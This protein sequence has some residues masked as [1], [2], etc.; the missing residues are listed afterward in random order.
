MSEIKQEILITNQP[1]PVSVRGTKKILSQM[2]KFICKIYLGNGKKGTGTGF[3]CK[4]PFHNQLLPVLITNN[5][6]L[7][8]ND[9]KNGKIINLSIYDIYNKKNS[10]HNEEIKKIKI[11]NSR[12]KYT[13]PD[14]KIDITIIE[15]KPIDK[16]YYYLEYDKDIINKNEEFLKLEYKNKSIYILH[17]PNGE[18][19][20]SYG[21]IN[22]II[23]KKK[24]NHKCSTEEGSSGSPILLLKTFKVIGIHY[25]GESGNI[26]LNYGTF[27]K[28]A[29]DLF[30]KYHNNNGISKKQSQ[31]IQKK[32]Q[33]NNLNQ[34]KPET[35]S[36]NSNDIHYKKKIKT[37]SRRK[38]NLNNSI[39][40]INYNKY[41]IDNNIVKHNEI[42]L[43]LINDY[44]FQYRINSSIKKY[45]SNSMCNRSRK[46][47]NKRISN[48]NDKSS[49][50][51]ISFDKNIN[52][53]KK[54]EKEKILS[55]QKRNIKNLI[56]NTEKSEK[57]ITAYSKTYKGSTKDILYR[58]NNKTKPRLSSLC[59]YDINNN[60]MKNPDY[61]NRTPVKFISKKN[62]NDNNDNS[63]SDN[64][65]EKSVF[66]ETKSY[67]CPVLSSDKKDL[68]NPKKKSFLGTQSK[69][70]K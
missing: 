15:I 41:T 56:I 53:E 5:H 17:Y 68:Y 23:D 12:K 55:T 54:F 21:L 24:I 67:I 28:Y 18:L 64:Y 37:N 38:I 44:N 34:K 8:E 65:V 31:N 32:K 25:G 58:Q 61:K 60:L 45:K 49:N 13:N 11:D 70:K 48:K 4:I 14:N 50:E 62:N 52:K 46:N 43:S 6:I 19:N 51:C 9:I 63:F 16:I 7:G 20:V 26:N 66:L 36:E 3:F 42:T 2:E 39:S 1:S 69:I 33:M 27:I 59:Y 57:Y 29:I 10:C 47:T 35:N 22:G 30:N 40:N